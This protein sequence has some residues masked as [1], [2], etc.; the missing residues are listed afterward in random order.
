MPE[1]VLDWGVDLILSLQSL[2]T[3][4]AVPLNVITVA[5]SSELM[6]VIAA[7]IYWCVDRKWGLRLGVVLML[8]VAINETL[9][10]ALHDPR[11]YWYDAR[12]Q[13]LSTPHGSFGIPSGHSAVALAGWGVLA[14]FLATSWV[15]L[16]AAALI[17]L[18]GLSRAYVGVHFPT[19][20][21]F[22]WAVGALVAVLVL[23]LEASVLSRTR[24]TPE[25]AQIAILLAVT[26]LLA[27][28]GAYVSQSVMASW[29]LPAE[30]IEN[31]AR[32]AP[33]HTLEP[34]SVENV[35]AGTGILFGLLAGAILLSRRGGF[36]VR[37]VRSQ[38]LQRF[39]LGMLGVLIVWLGLGWLFGLV[40][41]GEGWLAFLLHYL[42]YALL[43]MWISALAPMVFI[44]AGLAR[45]KLE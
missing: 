19:D 15:W 30:W 20:V 18:V 10:V 32:Q 17:L 11:P 31:A 34:F 9:K 3:W 29:Q 25:A 23:R 24:R 36:D 22:G 35:V 26:L 7:L 40:A 39:I 16:I 41:G 27:I 42:Q 14:V 5:G 8:T 28:L 13:L 1:A 4:L 43:G 44:R 38:L 12:V 33:D 2:G 6:L 21:L 45:M 37:G